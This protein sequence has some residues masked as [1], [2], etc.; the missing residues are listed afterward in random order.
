MMNKSIIAIL[1]AAILIAGCGKGGSG[2]EVAVNETAAS[3]QT[4]VPGLQETQKYCAQCH[5]L[6]SP[7]QHHPAAWPGIV[8]RMEGHMIEN[9]KFMPNQTEREV[10]IGYL[11]SGWQK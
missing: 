8:A 10:I 4:P 2:T 7:S 3:M 6:P 9:K 5:A 11:Q 1:T